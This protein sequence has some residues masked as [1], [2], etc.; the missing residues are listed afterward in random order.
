MPGFL[1]RYLLKSCLSLCLLAGC[2]PRHET[3]P[4]SPY[5]ASSSKSSSQRASPQ[6]FHFTD[7]THQAKLRFKHNNGAFGLRLMPETM[8]SGAAFIDYDN[9]G[10][11]D[12]F[13]VNS[14]DWTDAEIR[15]YQAGAWLSSEYDYHVSRQRDS[16]GARV[17]TKWVPPRPAHRRTPG[18]LYHNN[19]NGT[20]TDVTKGSGLDIEMF[21]MGAAAGDYDNDGRCD[22]YVTAWG[23]N[24]LFRNHGQGQFKEVARQAGVRGSGWS[25][26]A[27]FFDYDKDGKLDLFVCRYVQWSPRGDVFER[28]AASARVMHGLFPIRA[29]PAACIAIEATAPLPTFRSAPASRAVFLPGRRQDLRQSRSKL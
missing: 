18:A 5:M 23:R 22:L 19:G 14:R 24:Y 6:V 9:D 26:G 4:A 28:S 20:F 17:L 10:Y 15:D 21:G 1:P 29:T 3:P 2:S 11:Q 27:A 12:M 13:F 25:S 7:I 8:G 16:N